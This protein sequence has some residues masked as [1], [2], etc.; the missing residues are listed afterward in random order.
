MGY[1]NQSA[2]NIVG[3]YFPFPWTDSRV[4]DVEIR[5]ER[6]Y[7]DWALQAGRNT[8]EAE[9]DDS[10]RLRPRISTRSSPR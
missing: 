10:P 6:E 4:P 1:D 2:V 9:P 5:N 7:L 8:L 3:T